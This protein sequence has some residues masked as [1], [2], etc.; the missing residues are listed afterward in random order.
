MADGCYKIKL[1]APPVDGKAN[2]ELKKWLAKQFGVAGCD[3]KIKI[4]ITSRNKIV[5][6]KY[7]SCRPDWFNE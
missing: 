5:E 6:I 7:S 3:I 2:T 1:K 4:G